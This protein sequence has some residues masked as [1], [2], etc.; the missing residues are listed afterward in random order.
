MATIG[1]LAAC[2]VSIDDTET[3]TAA[4]TD[5]RD[6]GIVAPPP[7]APAPT[8]PEPTAPP[9]ADQ[10]IAWLM[11][12]NVDVTSTLE[13]DDGSLYVTG[14]FIDTL[15]LGDVVL[16]SRGEEDVFLVK[17]NPDKSFAWIK[18]VGSEHRDSKPKVTIQDHLVH[19]VGETTGH[20]DC[21]DGALPQWSDD[22][23]F[24]CVFSR[25]DGVTIEGGTFPIVGP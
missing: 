5:G 10:R 18:S 1:L 17:S 15:R 11:Q 24:F 6:D 7:R 23:F 3:G 14:T 9:A 13:D 21:G 8:P 25:S 19:L 22:D 2:D 16:Q 20:M 4:S 12:G